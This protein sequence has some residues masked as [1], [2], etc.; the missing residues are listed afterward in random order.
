[1][2]RE[3]G[4]LYQTAFAVADPG[5][6]ALDAKSLKPQPLA[7]RFV[8]PDLVSTTA[9][10]ASSPQGL[11]D[12]RPPA[13]HAP[14]MEA[15]FREAAA[16]NAAGIDEDNWLVRQPARTGHSLGNVH[17]TER[18]PADALIGTNP[19]QV[20]VGEP[21]AGKSTLLRYLVLDLLSDE[22]TWQVAAERWGQHLPVWLPFH[23]FTQRVAGRTGEQASV[24]QALQAWLA[25]RSASHLWDVVEQAMFDKRLLLIVDGLD[26]WVSEDAGRAAFAEL[27]I[28][29]DSRSLPVV[30]STRPYGFSRLVLDASWAYA[31]MPPL[32]LD[33]Q[34]QL[35]LNFLST[36]SGTED[37]SGSAGSVV[38]A[39]DDFI[40][41]VHGAADIRALSGTPLFL[42]LLLG[43]HLSSFTKLP[44][45]RFQAYDR[46]VQLLIADHPAQRRT[47]AAVTEYGQRLSDQEMRRVL[48]HVAFASQER[49]DFSVLEESRLRRD[50]IDAL[51]D[52]DDLALTPS[53]AAETA[54]TLVTVAEGE[55][56]IL[57]RQGPKEV[58]FLHRVFQEQ[59]AAE[60]I[61]N[62]FSPSETRQLFAEHV[63]DPQWR[64]VLLA[65]MWSIRRPQELR[66]LAG[67]IE[68]NI[69]ESPAGLHV[70]ETLAEVLFGP[71]GVPANDIRQK[72][73]QIV[74]A[75]ETHAYR[76]HRVRLLDILLK[77][78][79]GAATNAIVEE[80][81]Q[82]WAVLVEEPTPELVDAIAELNSV[83]GGSSQITKLLVRALRY[84][85]ANI[86]YP[87][88]IAIARRCSSD[89][90]GFHD[91]R[92]LLRDELLRVL[93]EMPSG[94]AGAA[95][96]AALALEWR[97][98]FKV[99]DILKD[100]REHG[101]SQVR[102]VALS[103]AA[104][105]LRSV[106]CSV[107]PTPTQDLEPLTSHER[108]WLLRHLEYR[109]YSDVHWGLL[110]AS[111]SHA[112]SNEPQLIGDMVASLN[113]T[114]WSADNRYDNTDLLWS[115]L[116]K[117]FP[118][119]PR[120]LDLVCG[121][122]DA[123]EHTSLTL[124]MTMG[125]HFLLWRAY[126]PDS[127][128]NARVAEAI[129]ARL[130][131]FPTTAFT[132]QLVGL[133]AVD[134]GP[135]MMRILIESVEAGSW[136][137]W[138]ASGL[139]SYFW[140]DPEAKF[141]LRSALFGEPVR[142]SMVA[143]AAPEILE[144]TRAV[145][146]LL[147]I[148]R[149]LAESG[150]PSA[151]RYDIVA[152][153]LI[154]AIQEQG[155]A[156]GPELDLIAAEALPL[157]PGSFD[158]FQGN[159]KQLLAAALYP[160]SAAAKSLS[161]IEEAMDRHLAPRIHALRDDPESLAPLL[162]EAS[163]I[164]CSVP[165][166][167]R[168]R[169][170]DALAD[171]AGT[172]EVTMELTRRWSDEVSQPNTTIASL[173]FHSALVRA[174]ENRGIGENQWKQALGQLKE[175][176]SLRGIDHDAGVRG[177][178][179]G[180]CVLGEWSLLK[181]PE[182]PP[183]DA[184][185]ILH[186]PDR[187]LLLQLAS[188]WEDLR[189]EFGNELLERLSGHWR[190][191]PEEVWNALALVADESSALQRELED[192]LARDAELLRLDGVL[193][194]F[195][196]RSGSHGHAV[197]DAL[198]SHLHSGDNRE[199]LASI[200]IEG[201]ERIGLDRSE[202][203]GRLEAALSPHPY[204]GDPALQALASLSPQHPLVLDAWA[205]LRDAKGFHSA[206]EV[207]IYYAVAYAAAD[208]G[209]ILDLLS[210]HLSRL[211]QIDA[212]F[213]ADAFARHV[214]NRL[215]RDAQAADLVR[216][217]VLKVTTRD[218]RAATLISLLAKAVGLDELLLREVERR[219]ASQGDVDLAPVARDYAVSGSPSVPVRTI[220]M[221]AV[222]KTAD[223]DPS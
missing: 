5:F 30:A 194:W 176:A 16:R 185:G 48:A 52:P 95:A 179:V 85:D 184:H 145:P 102:I 23:F 89:G 47:A 170:C 40:S 20:V 121:Q 117:T 138:A 64:E 38:S 115:V 110:V 79:G 101:D 163:R 172:P 209:E 24:Q 192:A 181:A 10:A 83:T 18:R 31:R 165:P 37:N 190:D 76:P 215:R 135:K 213:I 118:D 9:Q 189:T 57:V 137:H 42:L 219:I 169:I 177:A 62:R 39:L 150:H 112:V 4:G 134:R 128:N 2:R 28:F 15:P 17:P 131:R 34:R 1:M 217:E 191:R 92:D 148:L 132:R 32:T 22:P 130:H 33:Q 188:R 143:N 107:P 183:V 11:E 210:R 149:G 26:E 14:D 141:A 12:N 90:P 81:L 140:D 96:L 159:P 216:E 27:R 19:L 8:L 113:S 7:Q 109:T 65:T 106:L 207:R 174:R 168:G 67:L 100:A 111:V 198:V 103:H 155:I 60:H 13:E 6:I 162:K 146:R 25:Q 88:A 56:G 206:D 178:W 154:Q 77:G 74:E 66:E 58:G 21:G 46:A 147:A 97:D 108:D 49:G 175:Q 142:A 133:A 59:L 124:R 196:T 164:L 160:S 68:Q 166:F 122:L 93:S 193:A 61:T 212:T 180:A 78:I 221:R 173:A 167:L 144:P 99:A 126:P 119:D 86:A 161:E 157:M 139:V 44:T 208:T 3:L 186:G 50:F 222:D 80:C 36:V 218:S 201:P 75:I 53:E 73:P 72:A 156:P 200:L 63:R 35:A 203:V 195:V 82:R 104:G 127:P 55:L 187:P 171:G 84:P 129:E 125:D 29:A 120:V 136:P 223:I 54:G 205:E 87:A 204:P 153:A 123:D 94:L 43:L 69:R 91:E 114:G 116:L 197:A 152:L 70:R 71:Y 45:G 220:F 199:S 98:D 211:E 182:S 151:G 158:H 105:A 214:A 41:Q 51:Q 202:L